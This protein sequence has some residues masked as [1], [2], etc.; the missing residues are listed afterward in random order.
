MISISRLLSTI[1]LIGSLGVCHGVKW[2]D[3]VEVIKL[4]YL[5]HQQRIAGKVTPTESFLRFAFVC[6]HP[7]SS[8]M[9]LHLF[10]A[11]QAWGVITQRPYI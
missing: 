7:E 2:G 9:A 6:K 10:S 4:P 3:G 5:R 8:A 11:C 1:S